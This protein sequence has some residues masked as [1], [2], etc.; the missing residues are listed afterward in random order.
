MLAI[1]A[2]VGLLNTVQDDSVVEFVAG[3]GFLDVGILVSRFASSTPKLAV[4]CGTGL[5]A[6]TVAHDGS[7]SSPTSRMGRAVGKGSIG[8][9]CSSSVRA[10]HTK[11]MIARSCGHAG[12][13][14]CVVSIGISICTW[15]CRSRGNGW[16]A[17]SR[18]RHHE[19]SGIPRFLDKR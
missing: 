3:S 5:R 19:V 1:L 7:K 18:F 8:R 16:C 12:L 2:L 10:Q 14:G 11:S 15:N 17:I 13:R 6:A 9:A 4:G